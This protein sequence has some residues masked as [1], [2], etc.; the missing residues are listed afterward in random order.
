[1]DKFIFYTAINQ[2]LENIMCQTSNSDCEKKNVFCETASWK[3]INT[4]M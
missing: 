2:T 4:T 3:T 1:M